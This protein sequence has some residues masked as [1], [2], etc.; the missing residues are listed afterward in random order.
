MNTSLL[1]PIATPAALMG[2]WKSVRANRGGAGVDRV[3]IQ[4]FE[5]HLEENLAD[6]AQRLREDHYYP[7]PL[8]RVQIPK[9]QGGVRD[10]GIFTVED[11][12]V[13]RAVLDTLEPLFEPEFLDCSFG[14]RPGRSVQDAVARVQELRA[15]GNGW[16]VDAD[17]RDF[18]ASLNHHRLITLVGQK[19]A[20]RAVLR[21]IQMWLDA[22]LVG[23][24]LL[25]GP[26]G[27]AL[28]LL[29]AGDDRVRVAIRAALDRRVGPD[30]GLEGGEEEDLYRL[31]S[32]TASALVKRCGK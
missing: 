31:P 23:Q 2:A 14:Y 18:F 9:P 30:N 17:I 5:T 6:L 16:A 8:R 7:M 12:I 22:G 20:D 13:Q 19:V 26:W 11:R 21:L 25:P 3:T 32:E 1:D 28:R 24:D 10:L 4:K 29:E 15:A 27:A